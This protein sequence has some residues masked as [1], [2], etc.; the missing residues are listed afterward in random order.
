MTNRQEESLRGTR[1]KELL[2]LFCIVLRESNWV[3]GEIKFHLN[4]LGPGL[5]LQEKLQREKK[6]E[7]YISQQLL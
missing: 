1:F 5:Q 6:K 2:P 4:Q 7:K 3:D